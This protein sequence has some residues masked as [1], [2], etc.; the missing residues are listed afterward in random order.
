MK[1][2]ISIVIIT[3]HLAYPYDLYSFTNL[4]PPGA[5]E[6]DF[7]EQLNNQAVEPLT[8]RNIA[9]KSRFGLLV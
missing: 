4:M 5:T 1:K 3:L 6:V 9:G 2:T 8:S 7:S